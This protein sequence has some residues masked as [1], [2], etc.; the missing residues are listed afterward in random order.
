[1]MGMKRMRS[2]FKKSSNIETKYLG[3]SSY[4]ALWGN[5]RNSYFHKLFRPSKCVTFNLGYLLT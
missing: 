3:W 2:Y 1:M 5:N 4:N